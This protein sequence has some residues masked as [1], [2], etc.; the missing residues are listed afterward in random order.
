MGET[1][2]TRKLP[3]TAGV[4][5]GTGVKVRSGLNSAENPENEILGTT[6]PEADNVTEFIEG[7]RERD[8]NEFTV[9]PGPNSMGLKEGKQYEMVVGRHLAGTLMNER[10][11]A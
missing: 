11:K 4:S 2:A 1:V 9:L 3:Y 7:F 5:P 8:A 10:C 6:A